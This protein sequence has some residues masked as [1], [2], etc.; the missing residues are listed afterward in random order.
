MQLRFGL[1]SMCGLGRMGSGLRQQLV[2]LFP[3]AVCP[4]L[5]AAGLAAVAY[6]K[7]ASCERREWIARGAGEPLVARR[8]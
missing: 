3:A 1:V 2:S 8:Q 6:P 4:R 7:S 5:H